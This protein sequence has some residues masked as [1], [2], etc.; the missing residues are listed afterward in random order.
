MAS[1]RRTCI[2]PLD[3]CPSLCYHN[4]TK[5][6]NHEWAYGH[7]MDYHVITSSFV[8]QPL[9]DFLKQNSAGIFTVRHKRKWLTNSLPCII[10]IRHLRE[11][12]NGRQARLRCVWLRRV[13]SSPIS[14]TRKDRIPVGYPVFSGM[15]GGT[16]MAQATLSCCFAAIH[17]EA[18]KKTCR[19]HVFSPRESPRKSNGDPK[20]SAG[21]FRHSVQPLQKQ[22]TTNRNWIIFPRRGESRF[23][24]RTRRSHGRFVNR[25]YDATIRQSGKLEFVNLFNF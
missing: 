9:L 17:L 12:W 10:I 8:C 21:G 3:N 20:G 19:G 7:S 13:G 4:A 2:C 16:R 14:R 18:V 11:C 22:S 15:W 1:F 6:D 5:M 25:P 24:R 23:A